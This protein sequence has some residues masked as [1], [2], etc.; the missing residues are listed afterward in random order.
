MARCLQ[1]LV[2]DCVRTPVAGAHRG[3]PGPQHTRLLRGGPRGR[4]RP[5]VTRSQRPS[6][7]RVL[8]HRPLPPGNAPPSSDPRSGGLVGPLRTTRCPPSPSRPDGGSLGRRRPG[9]AAPTLTL[10]DDHRGL[11]RQECQHGGG[12]ERLGRH[13]AC[14]PS[15]SPWGTARA[16]H[17]GTSL[18]RAVWQEIR[19]ARPPR[20][21]DDPYQLPISVPVADDAPAPGA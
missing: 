2:L 18:L 15:L 8:Y 12:Y 3:V 7:D 16:P 4:P 20:G 9:M 1:S 11:D 19:Q 13:G 10:F 6:L 17:V 5:V 14:R 21:Y